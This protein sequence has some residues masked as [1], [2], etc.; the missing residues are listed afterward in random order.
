MALKG[1]L[2]DFGTTQ[3]LNLVHLARKTG[4]LQFSRQTNGANQGRLV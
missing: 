2:Q 1:N 3:L 4:A